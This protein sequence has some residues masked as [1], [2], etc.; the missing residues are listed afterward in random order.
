MKEAVCSVK[1]QLW[2]QPEKLPKHIQEKFKDPKDKDLLEKNLVLFKPKICGC[3]YVYCRTLDKDRFY[4]HELN[5][6]KVGYSYDSAKTRVEKQEVDNGDWY[7]IIAE[8]PTK[9]PK[10]VEYM[11]HEFFKHKRVVYQDP[12]KKKH[13]EWF[14]VKS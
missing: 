10:Y 2:T 12:K 5:S 1:P 4:N 8:F 3:A 7:T 13:I 14:L 11:V 9:Y 6:Y